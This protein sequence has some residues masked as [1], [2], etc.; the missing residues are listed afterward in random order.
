MLKH[1]LTKLTK[2]TA[3]SNTCTGFWG[4]FTA[5]ARSTRCT[6]GMLHCSPNR[7]APK[8]SCTVITNELQ[9]HEIPHQDGQAGK[10]RGRRRPGISYSGQHKLLLRVTEALR[11]PAPS[12]Q[13]TP[14]SANLRSIHGIR[15]TCEPKP[16]PRIPGARRLPYGMEGTLLR[17]SPSTGSGNSSYTSLGKKL[18]SPCQH[19]T[20]SRAHLCSPP[21]VSVGTELYIYLTRT[22]AAQEAGSPARTTAW[23][24]GRK[25][26]NTRACDSHTESWQISLLVNRNCSWATTRSVS[27]LLRAASSAT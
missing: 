22:T 7:R 27:K 4:Y 17:G 24:S 1:V 9:H 11:Q 23:H 18:S 5:P 2:R 25:H 19:L 26:Q 15:N 14:H 13:R 8:H 12:P 10:G 20:R 3:S 16:Q 6:P 21:A